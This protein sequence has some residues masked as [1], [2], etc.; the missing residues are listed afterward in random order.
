[1][2]FFFLNLK[3]ANKHDFQTEQDLAMEYKDTVSVRKDCDKICGRTEEMIKC[4]RDVF[5]VGEPCGFLFR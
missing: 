4:G 1:M 5:K 2:S 3:M